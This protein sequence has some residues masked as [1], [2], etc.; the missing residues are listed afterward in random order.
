[1]VYFYQRSHVIQHTSN[2]LY[3]TTKKTESF[4]DEKEEE[5]N[6]EPATARTETL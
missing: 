4:T 5:N 6:D 1:M 2:E 3:L